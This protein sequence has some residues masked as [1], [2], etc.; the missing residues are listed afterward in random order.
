M[1][2]TVHVWFMN[3]VNILSVVNYNNSICSVE[4]WRCIVVYLMCF[5]GLSS[6][7][8]DGEFRSVIHMMI[9]DASA[10]K[11]IPDQGLY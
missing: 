11:L 7:D 2:V 3:N 6:G 4:I 9:Y 5:L 1:Y 8:D 10:G